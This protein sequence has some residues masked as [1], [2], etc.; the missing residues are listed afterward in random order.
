MQESWSCK[1]RETMFR[2]FGHVMMKKDEEPIKKSWHEQIR[3]KISKGR[4]R[5][6]LREVVGLREEDVET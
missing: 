4:Q 5:L 3:G 1:F 6:R 2:W